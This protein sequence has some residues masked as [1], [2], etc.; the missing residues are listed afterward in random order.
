LTDGFLNSISQIDMN[1]DATWTFLNSKEDMF[2]PIWDSFLK[3]ERK[4]QTVCIWAD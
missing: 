2:T 1:A 4:L 3:M